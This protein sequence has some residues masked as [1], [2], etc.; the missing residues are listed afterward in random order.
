MYTNE[1][2]KKYRLMMA[3]KVAEMLTHAD[4]LHVSI[5]N[6]NRKIG[7]VMNVSTPAILTCNNCG[8]CSR[9]C[10]D[11]KANFVYVNTVLPARAK[12]LAILT[13]D[14]ERFFREID[15][16]MSRRKKNKFFRW[17]VSGDIIDYDYFS[18][19]VE[20]ARKH[21]DFII[22]TYTKN[23]A[24]VN[25]YVSK[26][27]VHS[28]PANFTIMFSEWDGMELENPFEFPIFTCK[29]KDGNKNHAPEFFSGLFKCPGNCDICKE[30][31]TGCIGGMDTFADEH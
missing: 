25:A 10:Y 16:K 21:P 20:N 30:N 31:H 7:R 14:R 19:M 26:N 3:K 5:S 6:G 9:Y 11:I 17:H 8:G 2:L 15:E 12:N 22:W 23:Y 24:V 13:A 4:T 1:T 29:L 18:R 28:I 27:G